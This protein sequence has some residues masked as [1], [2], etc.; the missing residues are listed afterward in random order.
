MYGSILLLPKLGKFIKN[1]N[2][3]N[4][5][6]QAQCYQK[7][8]DH[9]EPSAYLHSITSHALIPDTAD[10]KNSRIKRTTKMVSNPFLTPRRKAAAC[11]RSRISASLCWW[12]VYLIL[13]TTNV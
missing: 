4:Q 7:R 9:S 10:H 1:E 5:A 6:G 8:I 12:E 13:F 11:M 2:K 3:C